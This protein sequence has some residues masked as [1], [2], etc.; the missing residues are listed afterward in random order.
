MIVVQ[1]AL[2]PSCSWS[3]SGLVAAQGMIPRID[4]RQAEGRLVG[5][6]GEIAGGERSVVAPPKP[7]QPLTISDGRLGIDGASRAIATLALSR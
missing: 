4:L 2:A 3:A 5:G 6:D 1:H 7:N